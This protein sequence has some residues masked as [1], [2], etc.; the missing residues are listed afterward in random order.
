MRRRTRRLKFSPPALEQKLIL[1]AV[2]MERLSFIWSESLPQHVLSMP[3]LCPLC[4]LEWVILLNLPLVFD[5]ESGR[6]GVTH[7]KLL[8]EGIFFGCQGMHDSGHYRTDGSGVWKVD[9]TESAPILF[10]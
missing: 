3:I 8:R 2:E 9:Q 10:S 7:L 4:S 1:D 5:V 6:Q